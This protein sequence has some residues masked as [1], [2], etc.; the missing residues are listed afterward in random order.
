[1]WEIRGEASARRLHILPRVWPTG[2]RAPSPPS[3]LPPPP[4]SFLS[5]F[6]FETISDDCFVPPNNGRDY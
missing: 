1:M 6:N 3:F 2:L 5:Q 4:L